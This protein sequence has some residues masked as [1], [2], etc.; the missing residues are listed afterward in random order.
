MK[1]LLAI[2]DLKDIAPTLTHYG[3]VPNAGP[4]AYLST[5][6][7]LQHEVTLCETGVGVYQTAYKI[8]KALSQQK[9]HL[10]LKMSLGNAYKAEYP[11]GTAL[12]IVNEKPGD[13]GMLIGNE[14]K[15]LYDLELIKREAEPHV[16]GG[17]VNLTNAYMNVF[18]P[19]KKA[20]GISV[21][22]YADKEKVQ[23]R[24]EKYKA[25]CET[26]DGIGFTYPCLFEKQNFYH[27]CV[28]ERKLLSGEESATAAREKLN[29]VLID[30]LSKI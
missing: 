3:V 12:N 25:D 16:R 19:F 30:L 23:L 4:V 11:I 7:I 6:Q 18:M 20:V 27:L 13:Y 1:L 5:A 10:A 2:A 14:W 22:N 29:E 21:N 15:D 26:G 24:Q 28:V 9:Y 17:L 8:T